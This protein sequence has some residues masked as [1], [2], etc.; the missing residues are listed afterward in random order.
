LA[1]AINASEERVRSAVPIARVIYVEPDLVVPG[2]A[3]RAP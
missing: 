2:A 3:V 1:D